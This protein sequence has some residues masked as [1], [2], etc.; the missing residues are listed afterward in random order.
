MED[1][2]ADGKII[3]KGILKKWRVGMWSEIMWPRAGS[4]GTI[5]RT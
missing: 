5:L 3:L 1:L 2:R 4:I